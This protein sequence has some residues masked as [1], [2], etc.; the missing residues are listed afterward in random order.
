MALLPRVN[1]PGPG[2]GQIPFLLYGTAYKEDRTAKLTEQALKSGFRG[3][4]TAN[5]P[6]AYNE[7]LAGDG[8]AAGLESGIER[9]DV[10]IQSK[11]TPL[12]AHDKDKI[13]FNPDQDIEAQ[14]RESVGLTFEHLRVKRLDALLLHAPYPDDE[15]NVRAWK[16]LE[17]FVPE[18]VDRLGVS[19]MGLQQLEAIYKAATVKP[20]IVQNRFYR[21][22]GYDHDVRGFCEA[23]GILYQAFYILA[24]NPE[25]LGS[26]VV[27]S[28]ARE[29]EV[30]KEVALYLLILS[31]GIMQV[32]DGTTRVEAMLEDVA[33]VK[34]ILGDE[35]KVKSLEPFVA[36]FKTL[37]RELAMSPP[38]T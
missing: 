33:A 26:D 36:A 37:I 14:V 35:D 34:T 13:P 22:T 18:K 29:L 5:Y 10:F 3:V 11:F 17:T 19:N 28:T 9:N 30:D 25:L 12:W 24:H 4:D 31:L 27:D 16:V 23:H 7:P 32:L 38:E 20:V 1:V 2:S 8:I 21:P 6:T 15:D